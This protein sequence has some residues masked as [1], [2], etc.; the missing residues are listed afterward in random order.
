MPGAPGSLQRQS[1]LRT[2]SLQ[3]VPQVAGLALQVTTFSLQLAGCL[4]AQAA[5][6][7]ELD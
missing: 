2:C 5:Q 4:G 6:Y 3:D 7:T 1:H